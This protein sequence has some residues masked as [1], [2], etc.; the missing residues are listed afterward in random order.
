[1]HHI[2]ITDYHAA[3]LAI[4]G[5]IDLGNDVVAVDENTLTVTIETSFEGK[6]I[7]YIIYS[8][9]LIPRRNYI[10]VNGY[11]EPLQIEDEE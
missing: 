2:A 11:G 6:T 9:H 8:M 10:A 5:A 7:K 3:I 1:M 4:E